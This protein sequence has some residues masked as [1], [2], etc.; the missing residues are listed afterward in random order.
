MQL[1]LLVCVDDI[2]SKLSKSY[3]GEVAV[4]NFINSMVEKTNYCSEVMKEHFNKKHVKKMMKILGTLLRVVSVMMLN[5]DGD[6]KVRGSE[7]R[8]CNNINVKL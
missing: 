5:V 4:C 3:L 7:H 6:G 8:D 1:W 2:F